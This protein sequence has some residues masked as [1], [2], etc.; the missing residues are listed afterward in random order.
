MRREVHPRMAPSILS[1]DF[2]RL[3]E[4]VAAVESGCDWIH[5]DV[6]DGHFVPNLSIGVPVVASLRKT[7][8]KF[9]DTH[10]MISDPEKYA[11]PFVKAGSDGI[12]FHHETVSDPEAI[13]KQIQSLDAK[14]GV[15][16]NPGTAPEVLWPI[17]EQV[18]LVLVMT[19]WPGFGG[20]TFIHDCLDKI[21]QIAER[22]RQDQ[23]LQVDGGINRET[24]S[25]AVQAGAESLVAGSAIFGADDSATALAE[26]QA[27]S[28]AAA[29]SKNASL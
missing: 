11:E 18:D 15:A 25:L 7:T 17:I 22:L 6:M 4:E 23:V 13:I 14:V 24:V 5:V 27:A 20:Q 28:M 9:L 29:A 2:T 10:L 12:T 19:V 8:D 21:T 26:L 16:I 3:G 1:A